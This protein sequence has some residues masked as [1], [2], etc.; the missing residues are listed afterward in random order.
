M[1]VSERRDR[2]NLYG[3]EGLIRLVFNRACGEEEVR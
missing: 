2:F 1:P 3:A